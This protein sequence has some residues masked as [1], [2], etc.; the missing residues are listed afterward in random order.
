[1]GT[2]ETLHNE[3]GMRIGESHPRAVLT[4]HE[5]ELLIALRDDGMS[6]RVLAVK[7]ECSKRCVRD[8]YSGRRRCQTPFTRRRIAL[9]V[10]IALQPSTPPTTLVAQTQPRPDLPPSRPMRVIRT[11]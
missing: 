7:F 2:R 11:P 4:D 1:M 5:V 3:R 6:W 9:V 10:S 8:I